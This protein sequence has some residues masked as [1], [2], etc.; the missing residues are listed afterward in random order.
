MCV[1]FWNFTKHRNTFACQVL[2]S[3]Y[4]DSLFLAPLSKNYFLAWT[5]KEDNWRGQIFVTSVVMSRPVFF[6][7]VVLS[8]DLE[9]NYFLL[10][11]ETSNCK[12]RRS[13]APSTCMV[14]EIAT[15]SCPKYFFYNGNILISWIY[16]LHLAYAS[17]Y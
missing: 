9:R 10:A 15:P 5:S 1:L 7:R 16:Q 8:F 4:K 17:K 12:N 13:H 11:S 2:R 3:A 14:R 6:N